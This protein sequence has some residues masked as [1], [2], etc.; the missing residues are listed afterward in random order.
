VRTTTGARVTVTLELTNLGSWGPDCKI[1][2]VYHQARE[3]AIGRIRNAFAKD[4]RGVKVVGTPQV[5]AITTDVEV[6]N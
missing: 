2:Q 4:A 6:R 1:D 5:Q 3:A